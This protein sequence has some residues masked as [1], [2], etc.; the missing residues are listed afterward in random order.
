MWSV[1]MLDECFLPSSNV[2]KESRVEAYCILKGAIEAARNEADLI[3]RLLNSKAISVKNY[4]GSF[5]NRE[6]DDSIFIIHS[7]KKK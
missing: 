6:N 2:D 4:E 5:R 3:R 1:M 7:P